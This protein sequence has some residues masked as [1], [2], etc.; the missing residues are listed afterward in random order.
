MLQFPMSVLEWRDF[1]FIFI[2]LRNDCNPSPDRSIC[3][4]SFFSFGGGGGGG[5]APPQK[6]KKKNDGEAGGEGGYIIYSLR[7]V[8]KGHA[9][10]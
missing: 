4:S 9:S 10:R 6:K 5:G 8:L 7:N 3:L 1:V 2:I